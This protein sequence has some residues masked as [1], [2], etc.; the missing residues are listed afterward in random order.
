MSAKSKLFA[1][2][3]SLTLFDIAAASA[4]D[5]AVRA[6]VKA[7]A[8]PPAEVYNWAGL[9]VGAH[10][11]YRWADAQFTGAEYDFGSDIF[12]ARNNSL[13]PNGGIVG[14]HIGYNYMVSP[15]VLAGIEGD[16]TWGSAR[17]TVG[18]SAANDGNAFF[19]S[20]FKLT[21]QATVRGRLGVVNGPWLF[22]A[23]GGVAFINAKWSES[24][25]AFGVTDGWA[26]N[27]TRTGW[28]VGGGI[29][30]MLLNPNWLVRVEYLYE[31]FG[32]WNVPFGVTQEPQIGKIEL[33]AH[34]LR[35]GIS[36]KFGGGPVVARY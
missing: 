20:E 4:A 26:L 9:Y 11:G 19:R 36:Y 21:W 24:A 10:A 3:A 22:Y 15:S 28:T 31:N 34:K 16:W 25:T 17:A 12:A 29:E 14:A 6:P 5:M 35:V 33:D 8:P 13:R 30:Y 18:G 2:L 32:S 7:P 27:K 23:T 1:G